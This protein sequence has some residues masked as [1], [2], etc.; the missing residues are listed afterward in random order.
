MQTKDAACTMA[1][2]R[3]AALFPFLTGSRLANLSH[4]GE[5][6]RTLDPDISEKNINELFREAL[7]ASLKEE[8]LITGP[9]FA[10]VGAVPKKKKCLTGINWK[11]T[12]T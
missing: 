7:H 9:C 10:Q 3:R 6:V 8:R 4:F 5:F 2:D 12:S 1:Y 11:S